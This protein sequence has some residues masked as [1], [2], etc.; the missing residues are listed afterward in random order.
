MIQSGNNISFKD[1][2]ASFLTDFST[3]DDI[4]L[5]PNEDDWKGWARTIANSKSFVKAGIQQ[6]ENF[7]D[8]R[9]WGKMLYSNFG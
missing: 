6:P 9:E 7:A 3:Q 2:T 5:N 1:W 4:P 8:W